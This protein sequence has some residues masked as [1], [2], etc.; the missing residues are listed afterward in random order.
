MRSHLPA[1]PLPCVA[2]LAALALAGCRG[3]EP[4]GPGTPALPVEVMTLAPGPVRDTSEYLGTL[5]SRRSVTVYP[6][7][8]GYIERIAVRDGERVRAGQLLMVVDPRRERAGVASARAQQSSAQANLELARRTRERSEVLLREGV[9]SQQDY[10]QAVA[11]AESAEAAARAAQAQLRAQQVQLGYH[12][13]SAPFAGVV[14]EVPV[15]VGD[16]VTS[17]TVLTRVDQSQALEVSVQV[18]VARA[19]QV[20]VGRTQVEVLDGQGEVLL[21]APVYFVAPNPDG[22]TQLVEVKAAFENTANLLAGQVVRARVVY[23]TR[24]ALRVP[25]YA[26]TRQ[27]GQAFA[28]VVHPADGGTVVQR[29]PIQLGQVEGNTYEVVSGLDAGVVVA[30]GSLQLLR[31]GQPIQPQPVREQPEGEGTGGAADAG[32]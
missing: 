32:E 5:I 1:A 22:R 18:P 6:Q 21:S 19:A 16:Y 9:I 17:E 25:T 24:E 29:Q 7:V 11:Q 2:L 4:P 13:V 3:K 31:D 20:E 10:D 30:V 28:L 27:S 26:V 14:G 12:Q 23:A 8:D 15:N